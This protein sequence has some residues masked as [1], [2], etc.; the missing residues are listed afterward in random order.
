MDYN[1][2][3]PTVRSAK[4]LNA[5]TSLRFFAAAMIVTGH[6]YKQFGQSSGLAD[7]FALNQA[8][9][10]FFVLS[11]FILAYV[12]PAFNNSK[13]R[14]RFILA[15]FARIWPAHVTSLFLALIL[16]PM[17]LRPTFRDSCPW[18][19]SANILMIHS[20]I[21]LWNY[22]QSFNGVSWSISVEFFFYLCFP[23][24]IFRWEQTWFNKIC[25]SFLVAVIMIAIV[26]YFKIPSDNWMPGLSMHAMV[27]FSP[28]ARI[29]EF[30]FGMTVALAWEKTNFEIF[31]NPFSNSLIEAAALGLAIA[32]LH[33][34]PIIANSPPIKT[35][36]GEAGTYW[37]T[38]SGS[39]I[40]FGFLIF[41]MAHEKGIISKVLS[42]PFLVLLGEISYAIYLL[43]T[44]LL[45]FYLLHRQAFSDIPGWM[46]YSFYWL[47]VLAT[48]HLIWLF[49]ER[50]CR[51]LITG[52][53]PRS[54]TNENP[55]TRYSN[56]T[57]DRHD[58]PFISFKF[59]TNFAVISEIIFVSSISLMIFL[60]IHDAPYRWVSLGTTVLQK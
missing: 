45:H 32:G 43:H 37:I 26:N 5:L 21:P 57:E 7:I 4:K 46:L 51:K 60:R 27:Y 30:V 33:Y 52:F 49:V 15:R 22:F 2:S 3:N 31:G 9:S 28:L 18:I 25:I 53:L 34:I 29:F 14:F 12:Y 11:G 55:P 23:F 35:M 42:W 6:C 24:L 47:L 48:S 38:S 54:S 39:V 44:I 50:P 8:V 56:N 13:E 16:I 10:F 17:A 36:T 40:I 58:H 20:W 59:S 41:V 1:T 19:I